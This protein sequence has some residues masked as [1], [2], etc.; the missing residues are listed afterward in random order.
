MG[1]R[2]Y[3]LSPS[4]IQTHPLSEDVNPVSRW[5]HFDCAILP[6]D[7]HSSLLVF[8]TVFP[9]PWRIPVPAGRVPICT[10]PEFVKISQLLRASAD[11]PRGLP[12]GVQRVLSLAVLFQ[13][14]HILLL[15]CDFAPISQG[16]FCLYPS[17][18]P[19]PLTNVTGGRVRGRV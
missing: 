15:R 16:V 9:E 17:P 11:N 8:V 10:V 5:L 19:F 6:I 13:S 12:F 14:V 18:V 7:A 1:L 3:L 2:T 4:C